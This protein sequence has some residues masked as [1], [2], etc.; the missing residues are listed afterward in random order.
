MTIEGR[1]VALRCTDQHPLECP[2]S[3]LP[4]GRCAHPDGH[5]RAAALDESIG[6][7]DAKRASESI[8][9]TPSTKPSTR[10]QGSTLPMPRVRASTPC[11]V[12]SRP[13]STSTIRTLQ[14]LFW[15]THER[16]KVSF[17]MTD[18]RRSTLG[19]ERCPCKTYPFDQG[20]RRSSCQLP[21]SPDTC[22]TSTETVRESSLPNQLSL[23][24]AEIS[25]ASRRKKKE[26]AS[27]PEKVSA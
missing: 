21:Q 10:S 17:A 12:R 6:L 22:R 19:T 15:S 23:Q 3:E 9:G 5:R 14:V 24:L 27:G 11:A 16:T 18:I 2:G 26:G 1:E 4:S 20:P 25:S 8:T 7:D 13:C